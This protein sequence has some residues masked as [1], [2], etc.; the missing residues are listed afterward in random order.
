MIF[1]H[2]RKTGGSAVKL[3]LYPYLGEDDIIVGGISE[4]I[5]G[6]GRLNRATRS[7]LM[8]PE[9]ASVYSLARFRGVAHAQA[10]NL[11]VKK[12]YKKLSKLPEH[13]TAAEVQS[14]FP[15]EFASYY[16]FAF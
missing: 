9:P 15:K 7:A 5:E 6:G 1:F 12:Y 13:A 4:I 10:V 3:N 8:T 2:C 16:K 11:A 14:Y